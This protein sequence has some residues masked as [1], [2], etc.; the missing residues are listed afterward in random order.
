MR[1]LVTRQF[2]ASVAFIGMLLIATQSVWAAN[3]KDAEALIKDTTDQMLAA[4]K[5]NPSNVYDL[6]ENIILPKFNFQTMSKLVLRSDWRTATRQQKID[7]IKAFRELLVRTYSTALVDAAGKVSRIDY[8][9]QKTSSNKAMV[10][11]KV[12]RT[13]QATPIKAD[14]AMY[15]SQSDGKWE[16]YNVT[17]GGVSLVTTYRNEFA[18]YLRAGGMDYLIQM[19]EQKKEQAGQ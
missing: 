10:Y 11:T 14:Y 4:L 3:V 13:D 12:Y 7:F 16:V 2:F 6:V 18:G 5:D 15:Y 1:Q 19:V 8:S 9:S 17:V